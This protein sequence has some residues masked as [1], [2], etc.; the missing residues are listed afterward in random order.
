[1]RHSDVDKLTHWRDPLLL[2]RGGYGIN[3]ISAKPTL[4]PQ[5]G[6]LLTSHVSV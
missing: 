3:K 5:T 2:R 6:W 4:V 1:L